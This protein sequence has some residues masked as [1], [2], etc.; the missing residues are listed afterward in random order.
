MSKKIIQIS[1]LGKS[2]T[3]THRMT[4]RGSYVAL[5]DVI[6]DSISGWGTRPSD[7]NKK[8]KE[9]FWALKDVSLDVY[10]GEKIG[11]IGKNG[12]GK[13]TLLKILSRITEP[14]RGKIRLEGRAASL[15]EIGTGFHPE[16]T[17][18]ENIYLNGAILGMT[19][20]E[21][22][23]KFDEIVSFSEIEKFLD[24]PVKRYSS[25]M[26]LRLAFSVAAH[27]EPEIM[28]IDEVLAV[29]DASFQKK[30]MRKMEE[31]SENDRTILFVSHNMTAIKQLCDKVVWLKEGSVEAIGNPDEVISRYLNSV[32][33]SSLEKVWNGD[34]AP[35]N[36]LV[37]MKS[38]K[39]LPQGEDASTVT[40]DTPI[41]LEFIFENNQ[42]ENEI[43]ISFTLWTISGECV[44]NT[45]SEVKKIGKGI[46]RGVCNIPANLLNN[47]VYSIEAMII[48]N[49]SFA[50][51]K[52][53]DILNFEVLD[54]KRVDGWYGKWVGAVRPKLKFSLEEVHG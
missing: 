26:Y 14:T 39:I 38:I 49:R 18:R 48:K 35:G 10:E 21:I 16:L 7:K 15:L 11:I 8:V 42:E 28:L 51:F 36:E 31:T 45:A 22:N 54:G 13:T 43:N 24:T 2:Y 1:D 23:Q 53:K 33:D 50:V 12:S 9:E 6:S 46:H 27:L 25:G 19:R 41:E 37:R 17:G 29:G 44:F 3:I 32:Q 34:L 40:T 47:N 4:P 52:Q 30:C 20:S 5:K